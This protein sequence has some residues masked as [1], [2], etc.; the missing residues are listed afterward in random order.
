MTEEAMIEQAINESLLEYR[1]NAGKLGGE[2]S[3]CSNKV[4]DQAQISVTPTAPEEKNTKPATN[5][6]VLSFEVNQSINNTEVK[7]KKPIRGVQSLKNGIEVQQ[8]PRKHENRSSEKQPTSVCDTVPVDLYVQN[9][10]KIPRE[11]ETNTTEMKSERLLDVKIGSKLKSTTKVHEEVL[12]DRTNEEIGVLNRSQGGKVIN[13]SDSDPLTSDSLEASISA[14]FEQ[15]EPTSPGS[16]IEKAQMTLEEQ[17]GSSK[18]LNAHESIPHSDKKGN[19]RRTVMEKIPSSVRMTVD[20]LD[21]DILQQ[22]ES[23]LRADKRAA[24][25][26]S[27]SPTDQMFIECQELMQL[28]GIPFIIAPTEAEAQCAWLDSVGLVDGVV[29]DDNDAFL[30]GA[31]K[32]YRHIFEENKYVEEYRSG[33]IEKEFGLSR[34][35]LITLAM[36][37]GSDY[38]PGVSGVGIVNAVEVVTAFPGYEG[39]C[40]FEKWVNSVSD[41]ILAIV[42]ERKKGEIDGHSAQ[43]EFKRKHQTMKKHW[44]LP[45]NFPSKEVMEAYEQPK[46]DESK[47]KFTLSPPDF[48]AITSYCKQKLGWDDE[49]IKN[50]LNPVIQAVA[51]KNKQRT[52]ETFLAYREKFAKIRSKRLAEVRYVTDIF[53]DFHCPRLTV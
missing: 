29:T 45:E 25:G 52:I 46:L 8:S 51:E 22:E 32:V 48:D 10:Q 50:M 30:F 2:P 44:I 38:T 35:K 23:S 33:E 39:L 37:L 7:S 5:T 27:D 6:S 9:Q 31:R 21:M 14:S 20:D 40:E 26:Q 15:E 19:K 42:N 11:G 49:R 53:A 36:L 28:F 24:A 1:I 34:D 4:P 43:F 47:S 3:D 18:K 12:D 13:S 41:D 17:G 16:P